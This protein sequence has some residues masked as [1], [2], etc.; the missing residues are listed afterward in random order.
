MR[1][2]SCTV[3]RRVKKKEIETHARKRITHFLKRTGKVLQLVC[4]NTGECLTFGKN[5]DEI[6]NLF[7]GFT[8][9][10]YVN[11]P[12]RPLGKPSA[13]GFVKEIEYAKNGYKAYAVLKS[14]QNESSDNL[15]YEYL[16]GVKYINRVLKRFPCFLQTYGFYF[17]ETDADRKEMMRTVPLN[18]KVLDGLIQ[19]KS[20]DYSKACENSI[21]GAVLI[22]HFHSA[23]SMR[24]SIASYSEFCKMD[25][26]YMLFIVYQAL[27]SLRKQFTHYDL[28]DENVLI[29][30]PDPSQYYIYKYH[31]LD[32][33][34]IE[35]KTTYIPKIIDYGRCFFDNG[36]TNSKKIYDKICDTPE[37]ADCGLEVG[38]EW[39]ESPPT[40]G[41]SS[42]KKNESH[43]LR[44]LH[45]LK[46][47]LDRD[48]LT[49]K[50]KPNTRIFVEL[51]AML[52]KVVYGRGIIN[53]NEKLF[54]TNEN[55]TLHPDM[56]KIANVK[57]AYEYLK[58]VIQKPEIVKYN[59]NLFGVT[60]KMAGTFHIYEDGRNMVF[61]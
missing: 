5:V 32:G 14:S 2:P 37:C 55:L 56:S 6:T 50:K 22:Q 42:Q 10:N 49:G 47:Q 11:S 51:E 31:L 16:V 9:F 18:K 60:E 21:L 53:P 30:E 20:I 48:A 25:S 52:K 61:E 3:T 24:D 15:L 23:K 13:N 46:L 19:Q 41:I 1:K 8:G 58:Y 26:I 35:F 17:Y 28:H 40:Y 4:S 7:A 29:V 12:I 36:N 57:D 43:D 27:A 38:F 59:N 33:T 39:F 45:M 34:T 44:L 54:G